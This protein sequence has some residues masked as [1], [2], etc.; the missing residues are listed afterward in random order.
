VAA[1][2]APGVVRYAVNGTYDG[3]DVVNIVDM[4]LD[5]TGSIA[6]R[7]GAAF[8]QAGIIINEWKDSMLP[9]M[10]SSYKAVSVSWID[11]ESEEGSVGERSSTDSTAFPA[12]GSSGGAAMPGNVAARINKNT[13]ATRGQRQGRM[14]LVGVSE[15]W[16]QSAEPNTIDSGSTAVIN[17]KLAAFLGDI[18]QS[19]TSVFDF[20][21]EMVVVHTKDGVFTSASVVTT[22]SIDAYLAS[23]VRRIRRG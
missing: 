17:T 6:D 3:H 4:R 9:L 20:G 16:T 8:D 21:S 15:A 19:D 18:N 14:Y 1:L 10:V 2:I 23:Q 5:T 7:A 13:T 12:S 11:L 22:L